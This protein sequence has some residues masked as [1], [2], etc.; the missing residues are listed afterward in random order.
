MKD[1]VSLVEVQVKKI[2]YRVSAK[3]AISKSDIDEFWKMYREKGY[4]AIVRRY[5]DNSLKSYA[6]FALRKLK[7]KILR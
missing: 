1:N 6:R 3:P 5:T 2:I 7:R 4:I